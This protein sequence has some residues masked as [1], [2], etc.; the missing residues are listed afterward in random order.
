MLQQIT[1]NLPKYMG[2]TCHVTIFSFIFSL[3]SLLS[4]HIEALMRSNSFLLVRRGIHR[5]RPPP[6]RAMALA[7]STTLPGCAIP[8]W[9]SRATWLCREEEPKKWQLML[10]PLYWGRSNS[11]FILGKRSLLLTTKKRG[12]CW[13]AA[14]ATNQP[15]LPNMAVLC[16]W[17]MRLGNCRRCSYIC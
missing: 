15:H 2:P 3:V 1:N 16:G 12:P 5:P 14:G 6:R 9:I 4:A 7:P 8:S 17:G 11:S 10:A 13:G